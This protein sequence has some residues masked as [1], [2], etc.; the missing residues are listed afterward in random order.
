MSLYVH[1]TFSIGDHQ[2]SAFH[3]L[4][5][6]QTIQGHHCLEILIGYDWLEK[7]GD[8]LFSAG[9]NFLGKEISLTITSV[10]AAGNYSPLQFKGIVTS[11]H[12]GKESDGTHGF[13]VIK[14][15]S[16][17][18]LLED[19]PHIACFERQSL[20]NIVAQCLKGCQPYTGQ[21][22]VKPVTTV[23]LKY[24]VQ[25]KETTQQFIK[26][27]AARH[28]EWYFY[29]G[30]Q[31]IFGKYKGK[32]MS[33][34]HQVDLVDFDISMQ[35]QAGN[36]R[37]NGYEY[38]QD[39]VIDQTA[40]AV[41]APGLNGPAAYLKSVSSKLYRHTSLYKMNYGF[42]GNAKSEL[43]TFTSLHQQGQ[44]SRMMLLTA[45]SKSTALRIGDIVQINEQFPTFVSHGKYVITY[46]KHTCTGSGHYTNTLEGIPVDIASPVINIHDFPRCEPQSA[47][48]TDNRDPKGL[49]RIRVRFR[50][51]EQGSSPWLRTLTP[52]GGKDKGFYFIPEVYEE[53][54]VDF[55]DGNPEAPFV[56]GA[57]WNGKAAAG[58]G[59][60]QNNIKAIKTRSGHEIRLNDSD[61]Q[62]SITISDKGG[63]I[64]HM[65]TQG[66]KISLSAPE[67][68]IVSSRNVTMNAGDTLAMNVGNQLNIDVLQKM[69]VNTPILYQMVSE[70]MH[71]FSGKAL[72]NA[73]SEIK[74]ESREIFAAGKDKI[75]IHSDENVTVNSKGTAEMKGAKGN[76]HSNTADKYKVTEIKLDAQCIVHFR[77]ET[78]WAG[79]YG[80]DWMR[81]ADS[82]LSHGDDAANTYEKICG[83]RATS[84]PDPAEY[85]K[86]KG[87]YGN[88][89]HV[90]VSKPKLDATGKPQTD[91]VTK[92][93]LY[94]EYYV[95]WLC[96]FPKQ[97]TKMVSPGKGKPPVAQKTATSFSNTSAEVSM[98]VTVDVEPEK[99]E[100]KYDKSLFKL[101]KEEITA[102]SVTSGTP[103]K[104]SLKVECLSAFK[105]DQ[106]I[107]I[108]AHS[109]K[110]DGTIE[111]KLAGK[112]RLLANHQRYKVKIAIVQVTTKIGAVLKVAS[113][114]GRE[115]ELRK[116]LRQALVE[117][118]FETLTLDLSAD[119]AFNSNH[120]N[121]AIIT[122]GAS[123]AIQDHMNNALYALYNKGGKDY[124]KH[125]KIYF[126]NERA[127]SSAGAGGSLYGR[128]YG[129]PST[130]RSVVVF[131]P[132]FTDSTLA[133][134][135]LHALGL[136]HSFDDH[137]KHTFTQNLTDNIMDYSDVAATP[138]PVVQLWKWQWEAIRP[139]IDAE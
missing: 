78:S 53:V 18:I 111:K 109:K 3:S 114:P 44:L 123:D 137:G 105:K 63:N 27:L 32:E 136:Y 55:E 95:P 24:T 42:S 10:E 138:I 118:S 43:D 134:E 80:F 41:P 72:I 20:Q 33:L 64:I 135:C 19:N 110:A 38:R 36:T 112:L 97:V 120:S 103:R 128:S 91:P 29:N 45:T 60:V 93:K 100:I 69:M 59:D 116:Y 37:L 5:L 31:L 30:Q 98:Q 104:V 133:H 13:C 82:G 85:E 73:E 125:Y 56:V 4:T 75:F 74:I 12:T 89:T 99:L 94:H 49:G 51:Q 16:P 61:G 124:T 6:T 87:V 117:P 102:K 127:T 8:S 92:K 131:A 15:N 90:I 35:V 50:W 130:P 40:D 57:A 122:D 65:D 2:F 23:P 86:L 26:R 129:I 132:G 66:T 58:F 9:R 1:T 25:Y 46:L 106:S 22:A 107:E 139:N 21:P 34:T 48:V 11:I 84:F 96:L 54:W 77:P 28:G 79:D 17:D 39:Q 67:E 101:D 71:L 115:D 126:I 68:I 113:P 108:L 14:A 119:A 88:P 121:G 47:I 76:K 83:K 70:Y 52:Y 62:E 7:L 81:V